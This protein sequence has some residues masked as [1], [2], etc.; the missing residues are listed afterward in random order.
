MSEELINASGGTDRDAMPVDAFY[1]RRVNSLVKLG[2]SDLIDEIA[3]DCERHH[4]PTEKVVAHPK[5]VEIGTRL[6]LARLRRAPQPPRESAGT[7]PPTR[8]AT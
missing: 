2:R 7:R 1:V 4:A 6:A 8:T 5:P 3:Q